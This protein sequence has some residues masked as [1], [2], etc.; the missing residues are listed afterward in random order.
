MTFVICWYIKDIKGLPLMLYIESGAEIFKRC[1]CSIHDNWL[2]IQWFVEVGSGKQF[3]LQ[4][5]IDITTL[6]IIYYIKSYT[7]LTQGLIIWIIIVLL[8]IISLKIKHSN[9]TARLSS[10]WSLIDLHCMRMIIYMHILKPGVLLI[11]TL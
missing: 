7:E 9:L 6:Y 5:T 10:W 2:D 8:N 4:V 11:N 3:V 1:E